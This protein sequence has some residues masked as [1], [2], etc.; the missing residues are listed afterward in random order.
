MPV[1]QVKVGA[2]LVQEMTV[3][4]STCQ[5]SRTDKFTT[6]VSKLATIETLQAFLVEQWR[7]AKHKLATVPISEHIFS[8]QG[9]ILR[10]DAHLDIYYVGNGDTI[11][12]RLP[13]HGPV[14][15]PW[16]MSTSE[17]REA[18]QD[19]RAYR[20]NLLPEQLM[21][22]LQHLLQ[23][24]SRLERLQKATKRGATEDVK[25]IT[26]ELR[27]LDAEEAARAIATSSALPSRPASIKWPHP[28]SL[29][30]TVFFSLSALERSYQSIPR[31][32]FEPG[33][34][35]LDARRDWVF[36]KHSSLQKQLFDYKYMA[37]EKDFLDMVVFKE[38][39]NL[40][41]WFQPEHSLAALSTFVSN[42]VD[43]STMRKYEPLMLEV[44][45]WLTLGGH[46]GWE[47]KPRRDG[48]K[49]QAH[50][51]P[52]FTASIQRIVTNLESESFDVI[53]IKEMLVQANPSLL[54]ASD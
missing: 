8:F 1:K 28:P 13:G 34:F 21:Y 51:K 3:Y 43:P 36:A 38:E 18:L 4:V 44:P 46:N 41:F 11:F 17:L 23:R 20:P 6:R 5:E 45:K 7:I 53:A 39:A 29:R 19:R 26:Q 35:L 47:G 10:H 48:R 49:V 12:L 52:V 15:T 42:L 24:E 54:F 22:Q 2:R 16:A 40:V 37:Y 14:T 50:L 9:R 33:I 32:V 27:E 25:R 30:R 31:D